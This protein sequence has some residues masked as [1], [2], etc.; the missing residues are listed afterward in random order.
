MKKISYVSQKL[1]LCLLVFSITTLPVHAFLWWGNKEEAKIEDFS[2]QV[3][4]G[5]VLPF[6]SYD[7][8][9]K[10]GLSSLTILSLPDNRFGS[11]SM[12]DQSIQVQEV[13]AS[14]ALAGLTF[15]AKN[16]LGTTSFQVIPSFSDGSSGETITITLEIL[17]VPNQAPLAKD[18]E[19]FTYKNI[20]ITCYFDVID[21]END[22]LTF[23]I[24]DPSARGSVTLPEDGSSSFVYT[25]Y[26][27]KTGKDSFSYIATDSVGNI[28]NEGTV[29]IRIEQSKSKVTYGD[30]QGHP[31]HKSAIALADAGVFVGQQVGD[32]YLFC[33]EE[34]VSREEFLSLAMAVAEVAPLE[35]VLLTGFYDDHSIPTWSKGYV[36]SA[37]LAGVIRGTWDSQGRPI[38]DANSN[39]SLGEASVIL[40]NL[41]DIAQVSQVSSYHWADQASANLSAVGVSTSTSTPLPASLTRAEV[42]ELLDAALALVADK[43]NSWLFW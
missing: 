8:L 38:F 14:S 1:L 29:T 2:R 24:T 9:G 15:Q 19:L 7:F 21:S 4:V 16:M 6:S 41:L 11:L 33:P 27:N 12:G 34:T 32:T 35:E 39:I 18:M 20:A 22:L 25:P 5:T 23:Q 40:D 42:A 28:S 36:S 37:L 3:I 13:V 43:E 31:A 10:D 26:E 17:D 30:M